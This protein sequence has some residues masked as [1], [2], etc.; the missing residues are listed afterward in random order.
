MFIICWNSIN[1]TH[2]FIE[3]YYYFY[4]KRANVTGGSL[5][6][7]LRKKN[8]T[9]TDSQLM[10]MCLDAAAGMRYLESKNCIHRDLA[11]RNCLVGMYILFMLIFPLAQW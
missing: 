7:F 6:T 10:N 3:N 2:L 4:I 11:A 1:S 8:T 9:L 5:L